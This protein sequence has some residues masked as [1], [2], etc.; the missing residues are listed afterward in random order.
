MELS[1]STVF[2]ILGF[3]QGIFLAFAAFYQKGMKLLSHK[4]LGIFLIIL[5]MAT[6]GTFANHELED[7]EHPVSLRLLVNYV[8][9]YF[10]MIVG[11]TAYLHGNS[12]LDRNFRLSK[13]DWLHLAPV[14]LELVPFIWFIILMI[15]LA[16]GQVEIPEHGI[17]K[18]LQTYQ[19]FMELPRIFSLIVYMILTWNLLRRHA[20]QRTKDAYEW[21]RILVL[22]GGGII[23]LFFI[24]VV[25]FFSPFYETFGK[26]YKLEVYTIYYPIVGFIYLLSARLIFRQAPWFLST[27]DL[28]EIWNRVG[29]NK[30]TISVNEQDQLEKLNQ[31]IFEHID[32]S[33]LT[34]ERI[35]YELN[36]SRSK[37]INIIKNLTGMTPLAYIKSIRME[38][39]AHLI[40]TS[41]VANNSEA[42][43]AIGMANATQFANQYKKHFEEPPFT[44]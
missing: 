16:F 29:A 9:Y 41:K 22:F 42:A 44:K 5:T 27:P 13:K 35:A 8:P 21:V 32:Q 20:K 24:N 1:F 17:F 39:V 37:A 12:A 25:I 38:Y 7:F 34:I 10:I 43:K 23:T 36:A 30:K 26:P 28:S 15:G 4:L 14:I 33:N 40:K 2:L 3:I 31:I 18:P 6:L 11:P 19:R